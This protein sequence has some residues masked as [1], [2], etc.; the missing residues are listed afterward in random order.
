[1]PKKLIIGKIVK[2][3]GIKGDLQ[4]YPYTQGP[5]S[6]K[7]FKRIF[8]GPQTKPQEHEIHSVKIKGPK[9]VVVKLK[10]VDNRDQAESLLDTELW[11]TPEQLPKLDDDE[12]YHY[13]LIGLNVFTEQNDFLGKVKDLLDTSA[14]TIYIVLGPYG[15]ILIPA[16]S[17]FV[18]KI[19]LEQ[20]KIIVDLPP[21]L[22]PEL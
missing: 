18:K 1:M 4:V 12:H 10:G 19:D 9:K 15:E 14:H 16:V 8:T 6:L 17:Q 5:E 11:I 13:Q 3:H 21:G 22:V 7:N 20:G 2:A